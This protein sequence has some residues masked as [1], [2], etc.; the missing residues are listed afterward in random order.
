MWYTDP[1]S[2][3]SVSLERVKEDIS[4]SFMDDECDSFTPE[5]V[6]I[7]TWDHVGYF[8]EQD[9]KARPSTAFGLDSESNNSYSAE[10]YLPMCHCY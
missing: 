8:K 10:K 6:I 9:D 7:A 3:D 5:Y 2:N 1:V 4:K